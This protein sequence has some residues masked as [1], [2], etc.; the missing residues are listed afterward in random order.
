MSDRDTLVRLA[1]EV[2]LDE[3]EVREALASGRYADE[4]RDDERTAGGFGISA[5]PTFVVDR[6]IGASGAHPAEALLE[7]LR[8]GWENR[9]PVSVVTGGE[10]CDADGC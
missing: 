1:V 2:G 10:A 5:V 7:L 8:K 6:A 4:V 3:D 9:S